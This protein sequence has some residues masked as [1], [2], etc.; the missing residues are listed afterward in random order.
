MVASTVEGSSG[1]LGATAEASAGGGGVCAITGALAA[2]RR[3]SVA[4][5]AARCRLAMAKNVM[6]TIRF[7]RLRAPDRRGKMSERPWIDKP[8]APSY[9]DR[10]PMLRKK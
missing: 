3:A 10:W 2:S 1:A 5:S 6:K 9:L 8:S 4:P 7:E